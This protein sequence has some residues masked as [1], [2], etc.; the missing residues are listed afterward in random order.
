MNAHLLV[1]EAPPAPSATQESVGAD[2]FVLPLSA[3]SG[4]AL[5]TL[6][7]RY[8]DRLE[9]AADGDVRDAC[10]TAATGR[11]QLTHRL[12]VI[13]RDRPELL[14]RLRQVADGESAES[15]VRGQH[16]PGTRMRVAFL[17]TGQ[18]SQYAGM[19]R[20]LYD[21]EPVFRAAFDR[22]A[23][24]LDET[25]R[26]AVARHCLH[27]RKRP[28][29]DRLH[30]AGVVRARGLAGDALAALGDPARMR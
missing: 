3:R 18:G 20:E 2:R 8:A 24:V 9:G 10:V 25:A 14:R 5:Q 7:D 4:S 21:R 1:E 27:R 19:G 17:F 12:A 26:P 6:A 22:C 16:A 13:G 15:V 28:R 23:A 11:A 29:A 30:A